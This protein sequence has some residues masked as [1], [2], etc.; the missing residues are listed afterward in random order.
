MINSLGFLLVNPQLPENIG[1]GFQNTNRIYTES[2]A[3][4]VLNE[5]YLVNRTQPKYLRTK[6]LSR[7]F[8]TGRYFLSYENVNLQNNFIF[9]LFSIGMSYAVFL[10][11]VLIYCFNKSLEFGLKIA[12]ILF[13]ISLSSMEDL[14]PIFG[15]YLGLMFTMDRDENK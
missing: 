3:S 4:P 8:G 10:F 6:Y 2:L 9:N 13:V 7:S 5:Q 12:I 1:F 14:L 15:L 11:L